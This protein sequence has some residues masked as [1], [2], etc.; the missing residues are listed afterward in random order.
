DL[1]GPDDD[2]APLL[3]EAENFAQ[4]AGELRN[5][6]AQSSFAER[7]EKREILAYLRR[8]RT[9]P[10]R[11]LFARNSGQSALLEVLEKPEVRRETPDRGIG[12]S[13]HG[14]EACE[15][16]HKLSD[17]LWLHQPVGRR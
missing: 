4:T 7:P 15:F 11:Q 13:F 10:P 2:D 12:N 9:A 3:S 14:Q 8:R 5:G 1:S 6:V 16:I 17:A